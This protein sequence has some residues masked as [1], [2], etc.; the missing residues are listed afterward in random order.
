MHETKDLAFVFATEL[1]LFYLNSL[2][3]AVM[4]IFR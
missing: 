3:V 4:Q 2:Y 1:P